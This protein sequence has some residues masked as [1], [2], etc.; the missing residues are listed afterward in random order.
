M[1][2]LL[3]KGTAWRFLSRSCIVDSTDTALVVATI[4]VLPIA[5]NDTRVQQSATDSP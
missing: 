1:Q 4:S 2:K 3:S 5:N